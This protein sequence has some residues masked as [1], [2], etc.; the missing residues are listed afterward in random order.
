[1]TNFDAFKLQLTPEQLAEWMR[2]SACPLYHNECP[3]FNGL[4]IKDLE[5]PTKIC[6]TKLIN[7]FNQETNV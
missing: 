7:W 6:T 1:M 3:G 2:C 5:D 4:V